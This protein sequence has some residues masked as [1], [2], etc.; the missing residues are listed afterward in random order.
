[1]HYLLDV[2]SDL[3][4]VYHTLG[5][6]ETHTLRDTPRT[7]ATKTRAVTDN[8]TIKTGTCEG[9]RGPVGGTDGPVRGA[10]GPVTRTGPCLT[11]QNPF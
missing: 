4:H 6:A 9:N 1:M 2:H 10:E 3:E 8:Q 11:L 7:Y 5:P